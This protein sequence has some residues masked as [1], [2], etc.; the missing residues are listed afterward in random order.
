MAYVRTG[1]LGSIIIT[2]LISTLASQIYAGSLTD[3]YVRDGDPLRFMWKVSGKRTLGILAEG[4]LR[5]KCFVIGPAYR[6]L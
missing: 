4:P 1:F 2:V 5:A 6:A 3:L